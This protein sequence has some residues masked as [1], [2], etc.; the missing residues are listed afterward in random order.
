MEAMYEEI[1]ELRNVSFATIE[2]ILKK[3]GV[4]YRGRVALFLNDLNSLMWVGS[5]EMR[6][7]VIPL[8]KQ[9]FIYMKPATAK[10]YEAEGKVL[11]YP[12][13]KKHTP[14]WTPVVLNAFSSKQYIKR[15]VLPK[16]AEAKRNGTTSFTM[17]LPGTLRMEV[18]QEMRYRKYTAVVL[19]SGETWI[20]W[21]RCNGKNCMEP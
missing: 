15:V 11:C 14:H 13:G 20:A 12:T 21:C 2:K 18:I 10:T 4:P 7:I 16:I 6:D 9:Q 3:R 8:L 17:Q 19:S 1:R 5:S